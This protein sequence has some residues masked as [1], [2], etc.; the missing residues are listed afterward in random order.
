MLIVGGRS[1]RSDRNKSKSSSGDIDCS[2]LAVV[3]SVRSHERICKCK[4]AHATRT[5]YSLIKFMQQFM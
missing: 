3:T 5:N 1:G 4:H 2:S